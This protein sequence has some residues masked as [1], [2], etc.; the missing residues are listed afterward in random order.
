MFCLFGFFFKINSC[1]SK[2]ACLSLSFKNI[3]VVVVWG[4]ERQ[5]M[6]CELTNPCK[7]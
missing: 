3:T 2:T 1:E 5:T 6:V 7:S 4:Y